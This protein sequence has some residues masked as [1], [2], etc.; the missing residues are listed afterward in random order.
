[1]VPQF[2]EMG[3]MHL[4]GQVQAQKKQLLE[5]L[6]G[7]DILAED[8]GFGHTESESV[9]DSIRKILYHTRQIKQAWVSV[10]PKDTYEKCIADLVDPILIAMMDPLLDAKDISA[11]LC[12]ALHQSFSLLFQG[13]KELLGSD[14]IRMFKQIKNWEK[15]EALISLLFYSLDE[16]S[17]ALSRGCFREF[18]AAE[19]ESLI[20]ACFERN[21]K[22]ANIILAIKKMGQ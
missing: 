15:F 11:D 9:N 19:M 10:L 4:T 6:D 3:E 14:K 1:M 18:S 16:V 8:L 17:E 22:R 20:S 21:E 7:V 13:Y 5:F 2:R 12:H